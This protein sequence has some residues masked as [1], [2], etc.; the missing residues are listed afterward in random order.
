MGLKVVCSKTM[1]VDSGNGRLQRRGEADARRHGD[2]CV[3]FH[4]DSDDGVVFH[5]G[6]GEVV[7]TRGYGFVNPTN[8]NQQLSIRLTS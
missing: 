1:V 3:V 6:G 4:A 8:L 5:S 2:N 7:E